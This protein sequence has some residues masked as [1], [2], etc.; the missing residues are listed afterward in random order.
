MGSCNEAGVRLLEFFGMNDLTVM[1]T[2]FKKP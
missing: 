2:W 1:N